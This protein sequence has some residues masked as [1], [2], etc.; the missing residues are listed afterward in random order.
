MV[1]RK[2]AAWSG[3]NSPNSLNTFRVGWGVTR[4][5]EPS[6]NPAKEEPKQF[7]VSDKCIYILRSCD[8]KREKG[9]KLSITRV[10]QSN[11]KSWFRMQGDIPACVRKNV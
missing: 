2:A 7:P 5:T 6:C 9:W 8:Y 1:L 11:N 10:P 4:G 3:I